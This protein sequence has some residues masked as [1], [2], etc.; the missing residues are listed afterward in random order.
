MFKPKEEVYT[1]LSSLSYWVSQREPDKLTE[2]PSIIFKC[3]NNSVNPDLDNQISTQDLTIIIDIYAKT[4]SQCSSILEE[5][6][7]LMRANYYH[8]TFSSDE[9]PSRKGI[10]RINARFEKTI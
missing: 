7:S 9:V 5:V 1:I 4:S 10:C 2:M 6:E 8:M 3:G